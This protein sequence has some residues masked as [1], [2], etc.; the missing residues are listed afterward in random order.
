MVRISWPDRFCPNILSRTGFRYAAK[1]RWQTWLTITGIMLGVA[2]VVA[3]DIANSSAQ[4]ALSLSMQMV[5]GNA[6]HQILGGPHGIPEA[7]YVQLRTELGF[8]KSA[9]V[10]S[11]HVR[12]QGSTYTLLGGDPFAERNL[13]PSVVSI[14]ESA[15]R[16]FFLEPGMIILSEQT[17]NNINA[18]VKEQIT[19]EYQGKPVTVEIAAIL[20]ST[21]QA[22]VEGLIYADI[23]VA[24][25]VLQRFGT[26][27]RIDLVIDNPEQQRTITDWLPAS[28]K[29]VET[30]ARNSHSINLTRAFHTNLT[31]MSLLA[32]LVGGFLIYNSMTFTLLQRRPLLGTLRSLGVT[33]REIFLLVISEALI[34]GLI[35]TVAGLL[36]GLL[37]GQVLVQLVTRTIDD[38]YYVLQVREFFIS[39]ASLLKGLLLGLLTT[40]LAA[41]LP[42]IEATR[43][44]PVNVQKR[45][46]IET[47]SKRKLPIL[48]ATGLFLLL[49]GL[50]LSEFAKGGI[51]HG[52]GNIFLVI[53]GFS[54]MVP[55]L[56]LQINK[57]VLRY[58]TT[59]N[60]SLA[61]YAVRSI[62]TGISRTGL[63]VAALAI[64]VSATVGV[65]IMTS[66]FRYTVSEWLDQS[67]NGDVYLSTPGRM[68][69]RAS[70]GIPL[71]LVEQL[72]DHPE[73]AFTWENRTVKVET[74]FGSLRLMAITHDPRSNRGFNLKE[75]NLEQ[76]QAAF[77]R[78]EGI[79]ISEPLSYH[80]NRHP[81][82]HIALN[83]TTGTVSL[84]ILGVF[85]DYTSSQGLIVM[86]RVLYNQLWDD[87]G[88]SAIGLYRQPQIP[89]NRFLQTIRSQTA[90][91]DKD[92]LVRSNN[93][94]K[95]TSLDI[96]DRTF[97]IT[98]ALRLLAIGVAFIGVLSALMALQLERRS[99]FALLRAT[100]TTVREI[101]FVILLQTLLMG[102]YS[103]LLAI[104]IGWLM[105]VQLIEVINLRSFGWSMQSQLPTGIFFEAVILAVTAALLA[106]LYPALRIKSMPIAQSLRGE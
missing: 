11:G 2:I 37:L 41:L 50:L 106:G 63:A 17:A 88:I 102:L 10:I 87:K 61:R 92:I 74:E 20:P 26:I 15:G 77:L 104:P 9:P 82:D 66:S 57:L 105:S 44:Q 70:P 98:H 99:E 65:G 62:H 23:A 14:T 81:G 68:T 25:E 27:D 103:G 51:I 46:S 28:L 35:A 24:Q 94:I 47:L 55:G 60:S 76:A 43:T 45:S 59:F 53:I 42:A 7:H 33:R 71:A 16:A 49:T 21:D 100:G 101:A 95:T 80:Q 56:V 78:G 79:L 22:A 97:A 38:L 30:E 18:G 64:A 8:I 48:F 19:L 69:E 58:V 86:P 12:I 96:F 72:R 93:E 75:G 5:S 29:L 3:V 54:L 73:V 34:F 91:I 67:L 89:Q 31:A 36:L 40:L 84:P 52:F 1:H 90:L 13:R 4:K 85:Y 83:A 32:L 39:P 6:T